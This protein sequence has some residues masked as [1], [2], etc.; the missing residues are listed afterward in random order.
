[1]KNRKQ[2]SKLKYRTLE[3][4]SNKSARKHFSA[5]SDTEII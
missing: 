3:E 2:L 1:M 4:K 5:I